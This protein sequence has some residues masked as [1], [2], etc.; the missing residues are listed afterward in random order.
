[1]WP[2]KYWLTACFALGWLAIVTCIVVFGWTPTWK[3]LLI[4][5]MSPV[6]A[7]MRTVQGA[8]ESIAQGLNPQLSN[9]GDPWGRPMNY[10]SIWLGLAQILDFQ[11]E[12]NYL[13]FVLLSVLGFLYCCHQIMAKSASVWVLGIVFSGATLLAVE[14]GNNDLVVF[15]LLY[16][17]ATRTSL[18]GAVPLVLA[19]ALKIYPV[20]AIP[21]FVKDKKTLLASLA[22]GLGVLA[23]MWQEL[24]SIR[25]ATPVAAGLSYGAASIAAAAAMTPLKIPQSWVT[26]SI[27]IC[28]F[29]AYGGRFKIFDMRSQCHDEHAERWFLM[30]ACI[31]VGTFLLSSNWDYRLIFLI[32]CVP[33]L[34]EIQNR[35]SRYLMLGCV[36][37]A[38][39]QLALYAA[40]GLVGLAINI[41]A[42]CTL[43][44][45]LSS[46]VLKLMEVEMQWLRRVL[47][48]V[49]VYPKLPQR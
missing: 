9:P 48:F 34:N 32:L 19:T 46:M 27:I 8:L 49:P 7:D 17:S 33:Y 28:V 16:L 39:N 4:P 40:L 41:L 24:V 6:F 12:M 13:A 38:V 37:V 3:G 45:F 36:L 30:G 25:S 14:R 1:V 5:T 26:V 11:N 20:L 42:K 35:E 44:A 47:S 18:F 15:L 22:L 31:Y 10:P 21:A 2:K 43:F 29:I 23:L